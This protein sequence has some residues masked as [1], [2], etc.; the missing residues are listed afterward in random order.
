MRCVCQKRKTMNHHCPECGANV[1]NH[2]QEPE[3]EGWT[4]ML[5]VILLF[6]ILPFLVAVYFVNVVGVK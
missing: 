6:F 2:E 4:T 5:W 1:C 3:G